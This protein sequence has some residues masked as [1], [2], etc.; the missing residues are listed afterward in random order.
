MINNDLFKH[1]RNITGMS[2]IEFADELELSQAYISVL[3]AGYRDITFDLA[4]KIL[5]L[6]QKYGIKICLEEIRPDLED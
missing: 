6:A 4:Y 3:E 2:Q 5:K 1:I